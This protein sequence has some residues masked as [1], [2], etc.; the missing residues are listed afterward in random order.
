MEILTTGTA[1]LATALGTAVTADG[2]FGS[3]TPFIPFVGAIVLFSFG[4]RVLRKAIKGASKGK[5]NI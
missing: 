5:A 4:Y 2:L 1:D 3:L